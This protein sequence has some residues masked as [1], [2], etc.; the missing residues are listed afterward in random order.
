[1][2]IDGFKRTIVAPLFKETKTIRSD[3]LP[4]SILNKSKKSS[5][6]IKLETEWKGA[7]ACGTA[8]AGETKVVLF[9]PPWLNTRPMPGQLKARRPVATAA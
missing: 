3:T 5:T 1:M 7:D 2:L 6:T 8:R 9:L 4:L